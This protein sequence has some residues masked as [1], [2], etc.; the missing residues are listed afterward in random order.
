MSELNA[1]PNDVLEI[2]KSFTEVV[3]YRN[4]VV[5]GTFQGSRAPEVIALIKF[6]ETIAGQLQT[7]YS[8]HEW[9]KAQASVP[10][11]EAPAEP[12]SEQA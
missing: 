12:S 3:G 6:L 10:K 9:V 8:Q 11:V 2:E 5:S 4:L 7:A 1:K